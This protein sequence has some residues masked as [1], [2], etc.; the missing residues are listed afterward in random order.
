VFERNPHVDVVY[1]HAALVNSDGLVL[2]VIWVPPFNARL[3]RLHNYIIQPAV[4]VRRSALGAQFVDS[5]YEYA[6]DRELWTRLARDHAFRRLN[7]IVAIDR[8]HPN[9]KS[10]TRLDLAEKDTAR[11]IGAYGVYRPSRTR[12]QRKMLKVALR[13]MGVGI[14]SKVSEAGFAFQGGID[15]WWSLLIRQVATRRAAMP[16]GWRGNAN[17]RSGL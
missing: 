12:L 8:H 17:P 5:A 2:Y 13:L 9:R 1:G 4:F 15:G 16:T 3:L 7:K 14:I 11:L 10:Y 6:M